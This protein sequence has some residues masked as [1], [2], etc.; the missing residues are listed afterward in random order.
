M[1]GFS[2]MEVGVCVF[3]SESVE[4]EV[5]HGQFDERF[6]RPDA[7]CAVLAQP[8]ALAQ[9]GERPLY[10]PAQGQFH[11]AL[12]AFCPLH[13]HQF[14]VGILFYPLVEGVVVVLVVRVDSP[15]LTHGLAFQPAE[16]LLG[17]CGVIHTRGGDQH[18]QQ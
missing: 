5:N 9:P 18:R 16:Q 2:E 10:H 14:P 7:A 15:D 13:D 1:V 6:R 8:P 3:W 17:C 4:H 12:L 11:P